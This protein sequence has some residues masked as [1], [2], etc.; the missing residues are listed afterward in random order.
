M[1]P[2]TTFDTLVLE[3]QRLA[4]RLAQRYARNAAQREDLE[5]VAYLGLVKAA[6]RYEPERGV[7]FT[8]YALPTILGELRRFC[9]DTRWAVHVPRVMQEHVQELRRFEDAYVGE[10]GRS[11]STATAAAALDWSDED[12]LEARVAAGCLSAQSL[13]ATLRTSDGTVGE[14]I[15]CLGDEDTGFADAERRDELQ[16]ALL[17]LTDRERRAIRLRGEADCSTP[18]IAKRMG[19]SPPQASRLV[20]RA[21][22]RLRAALD[23]SAL[24][25][26]PRE[27]PFVR[28]TDADPDLFAGIPD[29]T[30]QT[31]VA[32]RMTLPRGRWRGPGEERK[33]LGLLVIGGALLRTVT[34][35]GKPRAELIGPGDVICREDPSDSQPT[36][37]GWQV[38]QPAEL[39]V[40]SES[41]CQWP[42]V[43][44][45]LL[46]RAADRTHALAMQLALT[47]LRRAEDR[48]L[49]LFRTLAD[50]WGR[51]VPDGVAIPVPLTHEM[52][53]MLVGVHRP[54]ATSSL[55]RL[56]QQ[57]RL[58]RTARDRWL[59]ADASPRDALKLAA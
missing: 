57:G 25:V 39:A 40:L 34:R 5:Q 14:V 38:V 48:L 44:E 50:R 33:V 21:V 43:V 8:T 54:A 59:L 30:R 37:T 10:H 29:A 47:D 55:R 24:P 26:A 2:E 17:R 45:G 56:E 6:R 18:E 20:S 35:D 41:L 7:A 13:N 19:L 52:L 58:R 53:A 51:R 49:S 36:A 11:A 3:H 16:R 4:R 15:E 1:A 31:T 27:D 28:L 22:H 9:R 23:D 32:R 46:R 42:A 12:V